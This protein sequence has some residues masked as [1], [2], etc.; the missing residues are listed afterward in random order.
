MKRFFSELFG[1]KM[2]NDVS[3]NLNGD[4]LGG[5][6]ENFHPPKSIADSLP[7]A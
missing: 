4:E 7:M 1:K 2:I 6:R 3:A 5:S